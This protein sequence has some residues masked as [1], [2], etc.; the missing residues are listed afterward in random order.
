[1]ETQIEKL[2]ARRAILSTMLDW[3]KKKIDTVVINHAIHKIDNAI[4]YLE[5]ESSL[6]TFDWFQDQGLSPRYI[7]RT[8]KKV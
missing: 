5:D 6:A 2:K 8:F 1:M 7:P 4:A 3:K